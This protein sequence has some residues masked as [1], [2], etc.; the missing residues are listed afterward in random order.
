MFYVR[1]AR[2]PSNLR[3]DL[4]Q[5]YETGK[6]ISYAFAR[7]KSTILV[8]DHY[9]MARVTLEEKTLIALPCAGRSI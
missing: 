3:T 6:G 4:E 9:G 2:N 7:A 8:Q 5:T 1:A